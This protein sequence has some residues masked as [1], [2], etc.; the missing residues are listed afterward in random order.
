VTAGVDDAIAAAAAGELLEVVRP[1]EVDEL[2]REFEAWMAREKVPAN[3][4]RTRMRTLRAVGCA[5]SV[6]TEGLEAWW[7][8]RAE[9]VSAATRANDLANLRTFYRWAARFGHRADDPTIRL[10]QPSVDA[11]TP[12]PLSRHDLDKLLAYCADDPSL[13]RAIALGAYAGVRVAEAAALMWPNVDLE[14]R[15]IRVVAGKGNK[16]RLVPMSPLLVDELLPDTRGN[17]VTGSLHV[18]SADTL[19]RRV[20]RA[21]VAAGCAEGATFHWL[22]HRYGTLAY[23]A[24]GDLL[25]VGRVMG[26]AS[27]VTTAIYAQANDEVAD[28]IA[29]AVAR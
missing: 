24:T 1:G 10:S 5:G 6:G 19:R 8:A 7:Y 25:A 15:R 2:S 23:Q 27:P 21:I 3:T 12:H 14:L 28:R 29:I 16:S 22:R 20:N 26:H 9:T 18:Y 4:A 17:V 11:G 13:R